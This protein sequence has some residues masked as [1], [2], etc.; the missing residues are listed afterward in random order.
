M[1]T[2]STEVKVFYSCAGV[3]VA[4]AYITDHY[5]QFRAHALG[6]AAVAV[7]L[8][9]VGVIFRPRFREQC[10]YCESVNITTSTEHE[11]LEYGL[12]HDR[13]LL[14]I[15]IPVQTCAD[16]KGMYVGD[17]ASQIREDAVNRMLEDRELKAPPKTS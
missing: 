17:D 14:E 9:I 16:C 4:C 12:A 11:T 2:T 3:V 13:V 15:D 8:L 10:P 1:A 7:A 5:P 6:V